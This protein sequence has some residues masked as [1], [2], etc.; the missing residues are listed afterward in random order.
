MVR[1]YPA[2]GI[3]REAVLSGVG[4]G[5]LVAG[6]FLSV[7]LLTVPLQ[8]LDPAGIAW[9]TDRETVGNRSLSAKTASDLTLMASVLFPFGL[10]LVISEPGSRWDAAVSRGAVFTEALFLSQGMTLF[11]KTLRD[12]PRPYAYLPASQ[13]PA[14]PSYDVTTERTFRSMP[15]GHSSGAWTGASMA[16][17]EFLLSRP[18]AGWVERAG[19]GFI[20]GGLAGATSTL[21]VTAG[22]HF[23]SDVA[24]GAGIGIITGVAVPLLHRGDRPMPSTGQWLETLGGALAGTLLGLA[25]SR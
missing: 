22:Q 20:G 23:P 5:L 12:R 4:S 2:L 16:M 14:N 15:S 25:V 6:H 3:R 19:V 11:A 9:G 7:D 21:R 18:D 1:P 10:A 8:G 13:R 24:V 17:T